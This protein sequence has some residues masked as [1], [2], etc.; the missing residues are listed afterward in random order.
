MSPVPKKKSPVS[1][2]GKRR[3]HLHT[4]AVAL[5]ECPQCHSARLPHHTCPS[6]GYYKGREAITIGTPELPE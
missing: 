2:R 3:S 4:R 1:R 5:T 6:C